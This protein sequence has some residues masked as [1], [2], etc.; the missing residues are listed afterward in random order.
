MKKGLSAIPVERLSVFHFFGIVVPGYLFISLTILLFSDWLVRLLGYFSIPPQIPS[1]LFFTLL[2]LVSGPI[3]GYFLLSVSTPILS[4]LYRK[5]GVNIQESDKLDLVAPPHIFQDILDL[6]G[7]Q[8][9][10]TNSATAFLVVS[11]LL[12]VR[13][14]INSELS[15]IPISLEII[16]L[17]LAILFLHGALD[18]TKRIAAKYV[19]IDQWLKEQT[20]TKNRG[21]N[22]TTKN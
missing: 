14:I 8:L 11:I 6:I 4:R 7:M 15:L 9:F 21:P 18:L 19:A 5:T 2:F 1:S 20:R 3:A 16:F 12:L 17:V 10:A 13:I 22:T